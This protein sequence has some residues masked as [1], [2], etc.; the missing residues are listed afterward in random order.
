MRKVGVKLI[1]KSGEQGSAMVSEIDLKHDGP[2]EN[3]DEA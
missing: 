1:L 2:F 3:P